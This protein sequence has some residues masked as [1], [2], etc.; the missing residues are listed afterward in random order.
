MLSLKS[1]TLRFDANGVFAETLT[2]KLELSEGVGVFAVET[3]TGEEQPKVNKAKRTK[4]LVR[5][6]LT[7]IILP[8]LILAGLNAHCII[9][10]L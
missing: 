5:I 2:T 10:E 7:F 4:K 9:G 3:E 1:E 8:Y 6:V